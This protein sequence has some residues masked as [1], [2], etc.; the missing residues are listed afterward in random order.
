MPFSF[1]SECS[2]IGPA[3]GS[4]TFWCLTSVGS[5]LVVMSSIDDLLNVFLKIQTKSCHFLLPRKN[6]VLWDTRGDGAPEQWSTAQAQFEPKIMV[7]N[8]IWGKF[9]PNIILQYCSS[10]LFFTGGGMVFG[11]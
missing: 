6:T 4:T 10:I 8:V 7:F 11:P 3:S 2:V 5:H 1:M 9:K